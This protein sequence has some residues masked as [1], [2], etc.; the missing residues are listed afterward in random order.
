MT[1][2]ERFNAKWVPEPNTGCHV[3]IGARGKG[4]TQRPRFYFD[5]RVCSASHVAWYF[6]HGVWP[7]NQL[8][9]SCESFGCGRDCVNPE[10]LYDG[11]PQQNRA[12]AIASGKMQYRY[13]VKL[14]A[15]DVLRIRELRA[16]GMTQ[17]QV[18]EAMGVSRSMVSAIDV[19]RTWA[20][21]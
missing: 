10:H 19:G 1:P 8:N 18:G 17:K 9:H 21:V 14:T 15:E 16:S 20:D 5:G 4:K 13:P 7:E 11:T 12:D 6:A 2:Q 3:W